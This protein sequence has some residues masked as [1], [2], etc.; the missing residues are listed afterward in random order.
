M[1]KISWEWHRKKNWRPPQKTITSGD[2]PTPP[3]PGFDSYIYQSIPLD[4]RIPNIYNLIGST[5]VV[6]KLCFLHPPA[7]TH[8]FEIDHRSCSLASACGLG[9]TPPTCTCAHTLYFTCAQTQ[10][11]YTFFW[12]QI[13]L[14]RLCTWLRQ[15]HPAMCPSPHTASHANPL[16]RCVTKTPLLLHQ[17]RAAAAAA[18]AAAT[19]TAGRG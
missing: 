5:R 18:A 2:H 1:F 12:P 14:L 17:A 10:H 7:L 6:Q 19:A 8:Y 9:N 3:P 4:A 11:T 15:T 13:P 16:T